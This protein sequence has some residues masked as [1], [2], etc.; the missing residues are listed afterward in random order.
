MLPQG[1]GLEDLPGSLAGGGD[2]VQRPQPFPVVRY[3]L[4]LAMMEQVG[5]ER[6]GVRMVCHRL[7][8]DDQ[9]LQCEQRILMIGPKPGSSETPC[10][11]EHRQRLVVVSRCAL[12]HSDIV[13]GV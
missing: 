10:P 5:E 2:L 3:F 1:H 13:Q 9:L 6:K 7:M 11:L 4:N 12:R 8:E